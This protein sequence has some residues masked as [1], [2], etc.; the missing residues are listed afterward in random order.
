M[1]VTRKTEIEPI[2]G[3]PQKRL[4]WSIITDYDLQTG[5]C[6]LVDN[7][8]DM[9]TLAGRKQTLNV[10]ITLDAE[11]QFIADSMTPAE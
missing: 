3:T 10:N 5:L 9:W 6:E 4:F 2:D 7:A 8:I 1:A 11:R